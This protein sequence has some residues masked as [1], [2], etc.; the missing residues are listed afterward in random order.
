MT[1]D[2]KCYTLAK[3]FV[4]DSNILDKLTAT[5]ELA[6][7]IQTLIEETIRNIEWVQDDGAAQYEAE[8]ARR[9]L[10]QHGKVIT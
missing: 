5:D 7:E 2:P 8:G 4:D 9:R 1:Y 10:V 6:H 3:A